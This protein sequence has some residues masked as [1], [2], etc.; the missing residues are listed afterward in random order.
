MINYIIDQTT[1]ERLRALLNGV[2]RIVITCH[3]SPDGGA[4]C[5]A[6]WARRLL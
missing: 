3:K 6:V 5:C 2:Q 4:M 1:I